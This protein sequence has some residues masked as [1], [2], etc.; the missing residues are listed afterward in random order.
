MTPNS[1]GSNKAEKPFLNRFLS[2]KADIRVWC[3]SFNGTQVSAWCAAL[4]VPTDTTIPAL[5][6]GHTP[7]SPRVLLCPP[8]GSW[9][10]SC[11][12]CKVWEEQICSDY[13]ILTWGAEHLELGYI[14][15]AVEQRYSCITLASPTPVL[16]FDPQCC[17]N[18]VNF[19]CY[20]SVDTNQEFWR[21][22]WPKYIWTNYFFCWCNLVGAAGLEWSNNSH[23]AT[24]VQ[25]SMAS[26]DRVA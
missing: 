11:R 6:D 15:D 3:D 22:L 8:G 17:K 13:S 18:K 25:L 23:G 4:T 24:W 21:E 12:K 9:Y 5:A 2:G 7:S 16:G 10:F 20:F 19:C 1:S 26:R 14:R